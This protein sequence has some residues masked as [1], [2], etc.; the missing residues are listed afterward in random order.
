VFC[1]TELGSEYCQMGNVRNFFVDEAD[2]LGPAVAR[3]F[4]SKLWEGE[5]FFMQ[6]DAHSLFEPEWDTMLIAD[7]LK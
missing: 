7:I 6:I 5:N 1:A 3:Y 4:A 2:A